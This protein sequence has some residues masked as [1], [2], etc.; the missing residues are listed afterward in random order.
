MQGFRLIPAMEPY[1]ISDKSG[2]H[3][4]IIASLKFRL[5]HCPYIII[6]GVNRKLE[7]GLKHVLHKSRFHVGSR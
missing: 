5:D 4:G 2:S 6:L 7:V 3:G 1:R